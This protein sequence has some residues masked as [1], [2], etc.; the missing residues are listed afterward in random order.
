MNYAAELTKFAHLLEQKGLVTGLEGNA[1]V[2]DRETGLTYV[3]PSRRM[4]L[5]LTEDMI[6][7]MDAAGSQVGGSVRRSSEY[8]LHEAVY[9]ARP[10]VGAV[11]H[12]HCPYL[13]AYA[14]RYEDFVVPET[15][16]LHEVFRR[17]VCLPWGRGGTHE[18]HRGI[19]DALADSPIC[20]LGG[21]GVVCVSATL[22]D[23]L[24]LL[25]AAE[26]FAKTLYLARHMD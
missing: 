23:C 10:D 21:H 4:K 7:V 25:E 13:T 11:I 18:I 3:T 14:I 9:K 2:I 24:S 26:G 16:S 12:C 17:F 6:A 8:L 19:E 20:L 15:C 1:S 22:E 5:L